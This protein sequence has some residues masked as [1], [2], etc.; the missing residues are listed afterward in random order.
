MNLYFKGFLTSAIL[1]ISY[2][3]L[4]GAVSPDSNIYSLNKRPG[5]YQFS[6]GLDWRKNDYSTWVDT[7][8]GIA[9]ISYIDS[10]NE[11][12]IMVS[13]Y[14]DLLEIAKEKSNLK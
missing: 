6:K 11:K 7:Q 1:F 4:S 14:I 10:K 8:N 5:R 12:Q 13:S 9:L 3:L 2:I